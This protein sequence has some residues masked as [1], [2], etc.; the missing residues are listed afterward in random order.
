[1]LNFNL[2]Q[3]AT[4]AHLD[5]VRTDIGKAGHAVFGPYETLDAGN[6]A[7]DFRIGFADEAVA[8]PDD[9]VIAV[10]D[11]AADTGARTLAF[12]M[13]TAAQ[14]RTGHPIR[15]EFDTPGSLALE[16]RVRVGGGVPL[17]VAD[18]PKVQR[19]DSS[20]VAKKRV[21]DDLPAEWV[22]GLYERGIWMDF[23]SDHVLLRHD[24][25]EDVLRLRLRDGDRG[26][27]ARSVAEIVGFR[28]DDSNSLYR[29]F[30][31][32][33]HPSVSPPRP[34]PFSST[35]C[36]QAHFALDQ[37]R[38]WARAMKEQPVFYRKQWEFVFIAQALYERGMLSG[39]K[40]GLVFGA[41]QEQLPALFASFGVQIVATDQ[42][43]ETAEA[44]GWTRTGQHTYDL[45][46]LN[47]RGICTDKMFSELVSY[48][49]VDMNEIPADLHESF[50]FCWSACALEHLGSLEHGLAFIENSMRTLKPGGVA[51]HTTEFNLTS[52]DDTIDAPDVSLY[53][54]RDIESVV[55]RLNLR[56]YRVA[57]IDWHVGEGFAET[58]IDLPPFGR[59][60]PHIRLRFHQYDTTSI[61][62]II[63][64]RA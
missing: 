60:E 6:Y 54:R 8:L 49:S 34:V 11:V 20:A 29:A 7:V 41:G 44:T 5:A 14:L 18:N 56:G 57:P 25:M 9:A 47:Q 38:F 46:A 51:I 42:A 10:V 16:Y 26:R 59:G 45:S 62:L 12:D 37:Y 3:S 27:M 30:I 36:Q 13:V 22:K 50:D 55:E 48:R 33:D 63:E 39:G 4:L 53:R 58:V 24:Q 31:G 40:S 1:M 23:S 17:L 28:G 32:N 35:L 15:L 52:N 61:G 2:G 64:R 19:R 43:P 21:P